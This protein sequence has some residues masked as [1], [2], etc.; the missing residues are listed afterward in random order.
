MERLR[1]LLLVTLVIAG[2]LAGA[3]SLLAKTL[4]V[5]TCAGATYAT[6]SAAVSAASPGDTVEVCPGTY[7]EQ[8]TISTPL[9]LRGI[10]SG[11]SDRVLITVPSGGFVANTTLGVPVAAQVLVT[12]GPVDIANITVDGSGSNLTVSTILAGIFYQSGSSGTIREV[13]AR[14]QINNGVGFA[15]WADN[16]T[17]TPESVTIENCE[18]HDADNNGI[19]AESHHNPSTLTANIRGNRVAG[20][21]IGIEFVIAGGSATNNVVTNADNIG[22]FAVS[23]APV[24]ISTNTVTNASV[25]ISVSSPGATVQS[26][27]ILESSLAGIRLEGTSVTVEF[28]SIANALDGI[29]FGCGTGSTASDNVISDAFIAADHVPSSEIVSNTYHNVDVIRNQTCGF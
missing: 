7:P 21:P 19:R 3:P 24:S 20:V 16:D 18:V 8:V 9:T 29:D 1:R 6:I 25:G 5:G 13:T 17:A 11:N 12:T 26:N 14:R 4:G 27:R 15:I 28:N 2:P 10:L 22:I 23:G